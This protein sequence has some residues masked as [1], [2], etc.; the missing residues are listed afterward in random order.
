[1]RVLVETGAEEHTMELLK[2]PIHPSLTRLVDK[3]RARE[4]IPKK[5]RSTELKG[6]A[7]ENNQGVTIICNYPSQA[8]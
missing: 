8:L 2:K 4:K 6:R 5:I 7:G 3:H 1:M